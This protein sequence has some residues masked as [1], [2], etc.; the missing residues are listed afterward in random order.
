MLFE[1][2]NYIKGVITVGSFVIPSFLMLIS[3]EISLI[4]S[5]GCPGYTY[6]SANLYQ[7]MLQSIVAQHVQSQFRLPLN[8]PVQS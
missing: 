7:Y 5:F 2:L 1:F 3:G 8:F 6:R 4:Q